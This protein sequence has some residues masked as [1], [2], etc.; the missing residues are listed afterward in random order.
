MESPSLVQAKA[1]YVIRDS[2]LLQHLEEEQHYLCQHVD[3]ILQGCLEQ[4]LITK[5]QDAKLFLK[6]YFQGMDGHETGPD[7]RATPQDMA[8][9]VQSLLTK[10]VSKLV[11]E[12]PPDVRMFLCEYFHPL[13]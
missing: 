10:A 5:P 8:V 3:P 6:Q 11:Q 4:V 9:E 7:R 1:N 12:R 13:D 2:R